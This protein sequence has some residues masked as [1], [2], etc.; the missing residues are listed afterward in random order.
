MKAVAVPPD[1]RLQ[2][3]LPGCSFADAYRVA[4]PTAPASLRELSQAV[5]AAPPRWA[6]WL[7]SLR[8][9]IAR[10]LKLK[11]E[12]GAADLRGGGRIGM[13]PVLAESPREMLLGLDDRHLD[14]RI[15]L[16]LDAESGGAR[17]LT[18]TTLVRTKNRLGRV[19]LASILPFHRL[20]VRSMLDRAARGWR[21]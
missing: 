16:S 5:L 14:F 12:A 6:A 13:F 18:V 21:A 11:T 2:A 19:Y 15:A 20:I 7:M 3:L 8:N 4:A 1:P 17:Q 9:A 10:R